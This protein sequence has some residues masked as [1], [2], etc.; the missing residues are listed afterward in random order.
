MDLNLRIILLMILPLILAI[1]LHEA[2][3]AYAARHFGAAGFVCRFYGGRR[4]WIS[5]RL[6]K[7][8]ADYYTKFQKCTHGYAN[9]G[10]GRAFV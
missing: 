8:C 10:I 3:H 9:D 4:C 6:G 5:L 7:T 1:T 2:A